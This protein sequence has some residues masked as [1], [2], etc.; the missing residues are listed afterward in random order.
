MGT[1]VDEQIKRTI[2]G[3]TRPETAEEREHAVALQ[4]AMRVTIRAKFTG[5]V[6]RSFR[7]TDEQLARAVDKAAEAAA[8]PRPPSTRKRRRR[9]PC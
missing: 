2:L 8:K 7:K 1:D 9:G 5:D 4:R 6:E 3:E